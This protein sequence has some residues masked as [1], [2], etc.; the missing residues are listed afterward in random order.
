V[1]SQTTL[2]ELGELETTTDD[3][4]SIDG[5]LDE[6]SLDGLGD[7]DELSIDK[8]DERMLLDEIISLDELREMLSDDDEL[9]AVSRLK[10]YIADYKV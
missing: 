10:K 3:E 1:F 7:G 2:H 8:L 4:L 9:D 6:G 5:S